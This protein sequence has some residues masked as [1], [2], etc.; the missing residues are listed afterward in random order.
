M[1]NAAGQ[2][3][4]SPFCSWELPRGATTH[5]VGA[6]AT[7]M[8]CGEMV[9]RLREGAAAGG[10]CA[11][12]VGSCRSRPLPLGP[13]R[14]ADRRQRT[15]CKIMRSAAATTTVTCSNREGDW[16]RAA[17]VGCR[18]VVCE[19]ASA[20]LP[21]GASS[22]CSPPPLPPP[23]FPS[24]SYFDSAFLSLAYEGTSKR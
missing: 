12:R 9:P 18:L 13:D 1:Q 7:W 15:A 24:L 20:F 16:R 6:T 14:H 4:T 5:Q 21:S 3:N 11:L 23:L 10:V 22:P 19:P 8:P 2:Y 17:C